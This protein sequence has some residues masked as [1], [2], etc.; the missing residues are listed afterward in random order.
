MCFI[1]AGTWFRNDLKV[2]SKKDS[3]H[4]LKVTRSEGFLAVDSKLSY[5]IHFVVKA[6]CMM[7]GGF[8]WGSDHDFVQAISQPAITCSK[9]TIET[10]KRMWN[11]FKVNNKDTRTTP[12]ALFLCLIVNFEHISHLILMFLLWVLSR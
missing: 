5:N 2:T 3:E 7:L 8:L 4:L 11:M 9:L 1:Y 6:C 12:L 10:P